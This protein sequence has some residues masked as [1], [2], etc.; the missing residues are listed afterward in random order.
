L[1]ERAVLASAVLYGWIP[2]IGE[3]T[4]NIV[5]PDE[6]QQAERVAPVIGW[7]RLLPRLRYEAWLMDHEPW[8]WRWRN[9]ACHREGVPADGERLA[10]W[11]E[12]ADRLIM[13]FELVPY[14]DSTADLRNDRQRIV[15]HL[16]LWRELT[17]TGHVADWPPQ[18][19]RVKSRPF[20][21]PRS[22]W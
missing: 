17:H 10:T 1:A 4:D 9:G 8:P 7:G 19:L 18:G 11:I 14:A 15:D 22:G 20:R 12:V 21:N 5:T 16:P 3:L 6:L 2:Q 13:D